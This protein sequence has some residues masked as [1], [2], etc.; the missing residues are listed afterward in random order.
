MRF[1]KDGPSIPDDLLFARDEGRVVLVCGAGVSRARAGLPDFFGLADQVI[2]KLRVPPDHSARKILNEARAMETRTGV[3]GLI[4]ADRVFGLLER[5]FSVRDIE[6]AVASSL[7]PA[8]GAD[9]SAHRILLDLAT[10]PEGK[11][12]LV[13]T[14]FERL[15]EN[16]ADRLKTWRPPRLP[17]PSRPS[18]MDGVIH[19]HGCTTEDYSGAEGDGFVLSS[20]DFGR[21]YLSDAWATEFFKEILVRYVVVFVGY[22]ADDPPVQYLLEAVNMS[23]NRSHSVYA[24]QAGSTNEVS[25]RWLHKGVEAIPYVESE[26]HQALWQTLSAWAERAKSPG[27]WFKSIIA[28]AGRG[29]EALQSHERGQVAHIINSVQG[30]KQFAEAHPPPPAQWLCVLDPYRRYSTPQRTGRMLEGPFIDPFD[31]YGLDSDTVPPRIPPENYQRNRDVP[32]DAWDGF[33]TNR[34]DR[35]NLRPDNFPAIRGHWAEHFPRLSP[36]LYQLGVWIGRIAHE[37]ASVW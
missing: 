5:D 31:L 21:A 33:A 17:D 28:M 16:C 19:L 30:A 12:R 1:F 37:P 35:Q 10:T 25:A 26:G 27:E 29:P 22:A 7:R 32:P 8:E 36:R 6:A 2:S 11:I 24:F 18:E 14:N 9:L 13:T 4:S 34:L 3:G 23:A 15:F 20:A